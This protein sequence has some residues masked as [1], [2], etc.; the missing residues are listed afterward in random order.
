MVIPAVE[1]LEIPAVERPKNPV[2][3]SHEYEA[4]SIGLCEHHFVQCDVSYAEQENS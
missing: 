3:V 2:A 4:A 1:Y